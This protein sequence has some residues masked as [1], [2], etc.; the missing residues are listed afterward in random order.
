MLALV[1]LAVFSR[2]GRALLGR[3]FVKLILR[4]A[5]NLGLGGKLLLTNFHVDVRD[6]TGFNFFLRIFG[7][8]GLD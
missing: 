4:L 5:L 7:F 2:S 6:L 8:G 1:A 3:A